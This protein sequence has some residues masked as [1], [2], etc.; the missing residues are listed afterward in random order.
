M[1]E[2]DHS[3]NELADKD[4]IIDSKY[5]KADRRSH[6]KVRSAVK[7]LD[8]KYLNFLKLKRYVYNVYPQI[9]KVIVN[10]CERTYLQYMVEVKETVGRYTGWNSVKVDQFIAKTF[11]VEN[12]RNCFREVKQLRKIVR[13]SIA[14]IDRDSLDISC[15]SVY[16][17]EHE[18]AANNKEA[19]VGMSKS[20]ESN[21]GS[22]YDQ[23]QELMGLDE[24]N[25][26][27]FAEMKENSKRKVTK[28][29]KRNIRSKLL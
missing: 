14:A 3:I 1:Y 25:D 10:G 18:D 15:D 9:I 17:L 27:L 5:L 29:F 19:C 6:E 24:L 4:I 28:S 8:K 2:S 12:I 20:R 16:Y 13:K 21:E 7:K 23:A 26:Y 11:P 22:I